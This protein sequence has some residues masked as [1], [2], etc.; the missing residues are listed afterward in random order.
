MSEIISLHNGI[1][2]VQIHA[3][4]AEL[5]SLIN[6]STGIN[7]MWSGDPAYWGKFSP[8]LFPIVGELKDN[9]YQYNGHSYTLPR[10]GFARDRNFQVEKIS[11]HAA[12]FTLE[13]DAA[14]RAVYPFPFR[15]QLHYTLIE[16]QV[17]VEYVVTNTGTGELLYSV[18]AH[19]AF[20]VPLLIN[21]RPTDYEDYSL[22][23]N[24]SEELTRWKIAG[25]LITNN[26]ETIVLDQHRLPLKKDLF[27]ED[28]LVLKGLPDNSMRLVCNKHPHGI[29][30]SW[31]D[32]PYIGIWAAKNAPF[33]CL[34]PWD[35]IADHVNHDQQLSTKEGIR[36]LPPGESSSRYWQVECF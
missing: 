9:T 30:F 17:K 15:L 21:D 20:A 35:G 10:H 7:Y 31:E 28:A 8:V 5:Q 36:T 29:L 14:S 23:F 25:G 33:V 2:D 19:P 22:V 3:R 1:L 26:Q 11:D 12:V 34:E 27:R 4:G 6:I 16:N 32:F 18:G 13:D 24:V